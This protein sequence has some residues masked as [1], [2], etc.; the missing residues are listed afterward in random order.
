MDDEL[1]DSFQAVPLWQTV[2]LDQQGYCLMINSKFLQKELTYNI[3]AFDGS[4]FWQE[5]V[6]KKDFLKK[7]KVSSILNES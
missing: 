3:N 1:V 5:S 7:C 6:T 4:H 2:P